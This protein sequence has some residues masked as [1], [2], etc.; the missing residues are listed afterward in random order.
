MP[1][2]RVRRKTADGRTRWHVRATIGGR[3]EHGGRVIH[4]GAFATAKEADACIDS[5]TLEPAT[6]SDAMAGAAK[7][8]AGIRVAVRVRLVVEMTSGAVSDGRPVPPEV[9]KGSDW[10]HVRRVATELVRAEVVDAESFRDRADHEFEDHAMRLGAAVATVAVQ[11]GDAPIA[12]GRRRSC[13]RPASV[14]LAAINLRP[15]PLCE[16]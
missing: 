12:S 9:L 10:L 4:L 3:R 7:A 1:A 2:H 15:R 5:K 8:V 16:R 6:L 13:P 14:G 11:N